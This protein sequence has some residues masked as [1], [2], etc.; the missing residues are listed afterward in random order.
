MICSASSM[1][2]LRERVTRRPRGVMNSATERPSA[3]RSRGMSRS[4]RIPASTPL[5]FVSSMRIPLAVW[6]RMALRAWAMVAVR[7]R[8]TG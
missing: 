3:A 2:T 8:T 5:F 7:S 4:D 1:V 6:L